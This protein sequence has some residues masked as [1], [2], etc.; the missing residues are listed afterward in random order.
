MY[1]RP[2][3]FP[4]EQPE[5]DEEAEGAPDEEEAQGAIPGWTAEMD[6]RRKEKSGRRK[7]GAGPKVQSKGGRGPQSENRTGPSGGSA[8]GT[9]SRCKRVQTRVP[10]V[11]HEE[12]FDLPLDVLTVA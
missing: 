10:R 5:V 9:A 8:Q 11:Q 3:D 1:I 7:G 4:K 2:A 12:A 6:G